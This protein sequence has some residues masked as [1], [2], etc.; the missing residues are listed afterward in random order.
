MSE[1]SSPADR[2]RH[3]ISLR[4]RMIRALLAPRYGGPQH[5]TPGGL[6]LTATPEQARR[7]RAGQTVDTVLAELPG[8]VSQAVELLALA[9][10]LEI[11]RPGN[12]LP[13]QLRRSYG[14]EDRWAICDREGRR[15]HREHGWVM[16]DDGLRDEKDRDASRYTLAEAVPL[17]RRLAEEPPATPA[18]P[19]SL[20]TPCTRLGCGHSLNWHF[21]E[22]GCTVNGP[23]RC[24]CPEFQSPAADQSREC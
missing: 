11:P 10:V 3:L 24:L 4:E 15:W 1:T 7:H 13:L 9:T 12:A 19:L 21:D 23:T 18:R 2:D 20:G 6:P 22:H 14:Y 17:A 5:N 8:E 16:Q